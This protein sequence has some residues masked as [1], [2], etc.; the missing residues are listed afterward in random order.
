MDSVKDSG[1]IIIMG[2]FNINMDMTVN[3]VYNSE[4]RDQLLDVL[5]EAG[6]TQSGPGRGPHSQGGQ[7]QGSPKSAYGMAL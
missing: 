1:N 3:E 5:P 7:G 4:M 2:D 6:F